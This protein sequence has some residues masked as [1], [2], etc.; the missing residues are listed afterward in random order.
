MPEG[1]AAYCSAFCLTPSRHSNLGILPKTTCLVLEG[2]PAFFLQ[3]QIADTYFEHLEVESV[4]VLKS[5][6]KNADLHILECNLINL[7]N[8]FQKLS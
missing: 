3:Q 1:Q 4:P 2:S 6:T 7:W 5:S 8:L